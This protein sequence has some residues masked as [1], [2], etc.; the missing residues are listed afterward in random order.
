MLKTMTKRLSIW[1]RFKQLDRTYQ[2]LLHKALS[3]DNR[4]A[5]L[6]LEEQYWYQTACLLEERREVRKAQMMGTT[7][8]PS[9]RHQTG[10]GNP[11]FTSHKPR[12]HFGSERD[13]T[14]QHRNAAWGLIG[15]ILGS[16]VTL[17]FGFWLVAINPSTQ[18]V[19]LTWMP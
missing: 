4:E 1:W 6:K 15:L 13:I 18:L 3:F 8:V 5:L 12:E 16:V 10:N 7:H 9:H 19:S 2:P 14:Y 17:G 11:V